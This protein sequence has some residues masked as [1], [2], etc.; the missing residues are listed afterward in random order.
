MSIPKSMPEYLAMQAGMAAFLRSR[1]EALLKALEPAVALAEEYV[2]EDPASALGQRAQSVL[3]NNRQLGGEL[4][5]VDAVIKA[6]RS[7]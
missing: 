7:A 5:T 1:V 6:S 3:A 4:K 2:K